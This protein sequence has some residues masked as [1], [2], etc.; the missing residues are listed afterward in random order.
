MISAV[1]DDGE[2]DRPGQRCPLPF[3]SELRVLQ[4]LLE[5]LVVGLQL[6]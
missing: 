4:L 1:P 2:R 5:D 3:G 6:A